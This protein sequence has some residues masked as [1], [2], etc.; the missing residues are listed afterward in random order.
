MAYHDC[1][2]S[3]ILY[4]VGEINFVEW[5]SFCNFAPTN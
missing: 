4:G 2:L 5:N 3:F 1:L